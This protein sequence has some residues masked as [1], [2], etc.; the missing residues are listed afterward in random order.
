MDEQD[1][2]ALARIEATPDGKR[3]LA[4]LEARRE[5]CRDQLERVPESAQVFKLQGSADTLKDLIG[6]LEGAR[7]IVNKRYSQ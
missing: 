1:W 5:E 2:K 3:L 7:D 4:I 6:N